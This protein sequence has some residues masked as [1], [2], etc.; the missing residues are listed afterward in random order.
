MNT[1]CLDH[2][3]CNCKQSLSF[4]KHLSNEHSLH[5]FPHRFCVCRHLGA[6]LKVCGGIFAEVVGLL[7]WGG[8]TLL[9]L[10]CRASAPLFHGDANARLTAHP[11][12][13]ACFSV[14]S[15]LKKIE[16]S[17]QNPKKKQETVEFHRRT[18]SEHT[19]HQHPPHPNCRKC[20]WLFSWTHLFLLQ[21]HCPSAL[22]CRCGREHW[23]DG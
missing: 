9:G 22:S 7:Q 8:G 13:C 5:F 15:F 16:Q 4:S 18:H 11:A 14:P 23:S 21:N 2:N 12:R 1:P 3:F 19:V 10:G 20:H 17:M 6:F